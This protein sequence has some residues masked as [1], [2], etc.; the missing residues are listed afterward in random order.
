MYVHSKPAPI[1]LLCLD[2]KIHEV[3]KEIDLLLRA[4]EL[5][6][7]LACFD[8][9]R[10]VLFHIVSQVPLMEKI[11]YFTAGEGSPYSKAPSLQKIK[12]KIKYYQDSI[13]VILDHLLELRR[14]NAITYF[15]K[16]GVVQHVTI[17]DFMGVSVGVYAVAAPPLKW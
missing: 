4:V 9:W 17:A 8:A 14:G 6:M 16:E 7:D 3:R 1:I 15:E 11:G 2:R 5:K 10:E 12:I 13:E